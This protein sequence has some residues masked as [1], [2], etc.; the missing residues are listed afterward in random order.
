MN[1][2]SPDD[3]AFPVSAGILLGLGL[4]GFFDGIVLHQVL[5]WHHLLSSAGYPPVSVPNLQ[6][7]VLWDG[8]FHLS[9]YVFTVLGLFILWRRSRRTHIRW[10]GK[11]LVAT[12]LM[13]FGIFNLV[14]GI[15]DHQLLGLHHVNETVPREQWIYWDMGFLVWGAAMLIGGWLLLR[16]GRRDTDRNEAMQVPRS[17]R[18]PS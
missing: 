15:V 6:V 8:L 9:T 14:E 3:Q 1:R 5:Q 4:G 7:N 10:S 18:R 13:G 11:L 12:I 17:G 2:D 16:A